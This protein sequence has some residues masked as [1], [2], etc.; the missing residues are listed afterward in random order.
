MSAFLNVCR[1]NPT[2]GGTTDWT[3]SIAVPGYQSP[4]AAGVVNG[5]PYS[6]RAESADLS[7][8]EVG[9]GTYNTSTGVLARTTVL[10]N[11]AGTGANS[12]QSGAGSKINFSAT[13]QVAIVALREDL[14]AIEEANSFTAAQQAQALANLNAKFGQC[15]LVLSGGNL[16]LLPRDGN[17]LTINGRPCAIPAG[18]VSLSPSGLSSGTFYYIYATSTNGV[19]S[20]LEASTTGHS[21]S[22]A[23]GNVGVEIKTGDNTRSLVGMALPQ[24]SAW[25]DTPSARFVRSWFNRVRAP[26]LSSSGTNTGVNA[27]MQEVSAAYRIGF[28]CWADDEIAMQGITSYYSS[29][30]SGVLN[31]AIN[32]DG[33][34]TRTASQVNP[35]GTGRVLPNPCFDYAVLSEGAHYATIYGSLSAGTASLYGGTYLMGS[36][37]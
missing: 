20:T 6:Y 27:A 32:Y 34:N 18:G 19:V 28:L 17:L 9:T 12:G 36:V 1:F 22:S 10:Y 11:S 35:D 37:G 24:A 14:I 3:Y 31:F 15:R 25:T 2:A 16:M 8:W 29:A 4:A 13:P 30:A 7:Q 33:V 21:P 26:L 23:A 5:A